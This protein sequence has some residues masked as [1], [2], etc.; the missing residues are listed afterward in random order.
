MYQEKAKCWGANKIVIDAI[1][2]NKF[3]SLMKLTAARLNSEKSTEIVNIFYAE[4]ASIVYYMIVEL[5][6]ARF[7]N[8][9]R[10][11]ADGVSFEEALDQ[12]DS[13]FRSIQD[14]NERLVG[15]LKSQME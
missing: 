9:C 1:R 12:D 15:Y 14:L 10:N 8:F 11:L 3:I 13:S 6:Q 7:E 5:G 2:D 4:S